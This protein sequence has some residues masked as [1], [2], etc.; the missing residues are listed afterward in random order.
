L[1]KMNPPPKTEIMAGC[2]HMFS[3]ER[4]ECGNRNEHEGRFL[5][6]FVVRAALPLKLPQQRGGRYKL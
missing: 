4:R 5:W 6:L 2:K 3:V 1:K